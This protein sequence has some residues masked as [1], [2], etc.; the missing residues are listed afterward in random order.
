[1]SAFW[2][3][4]RLSPAVA[5]DSHKNTEVR[6]ALQPLVDPGNV[7]ASCVGISHFAKGSAG[8]DPMW[9]AWWLMAFGAVA[10]VVMAAAKVKGEAGEKTRRILLCAARATSARTTAASSTALIRPSWTPSR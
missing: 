9:S 4:I 1:M 6:R 10:R 2:L 3:L 5:G 8:R 7:R